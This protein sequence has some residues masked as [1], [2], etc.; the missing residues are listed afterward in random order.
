MKVG[1]PFLGSGVNTEMNKE[2]KIG[3]IRTITKTADILSY[4][5]SSR[6]SRSVLAGERA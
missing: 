5:C 1:K 4:L 3:L 2:A 6:T